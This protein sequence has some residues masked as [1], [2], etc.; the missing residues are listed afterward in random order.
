[1]TGTDRRQAQTWRDGEKRCLDLYWTWEPAGIPGL[2]KLA[3]SVE[4]GPGNV[5][6][7]VGRSRPPE[8]FQLWLE[9]PVGDGKLARL[10]MC[11][12]HG[13]DVHWHWYEDMPGIAEDTSSVP[14]LGQNPGRDELTAHFVT[15]LKIVNV[16]TQEGLPWPT[17]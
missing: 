6:R 14:R 13:S 15:R 10:C 7:V 9:P 11:R 5:M 4:Y 8:L 12:L 1:M 16:N 2:E 3:G 17:N